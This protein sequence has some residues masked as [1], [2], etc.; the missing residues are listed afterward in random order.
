MALDRELNIEANTEIPPTDLGV[1]LE[2]L[3]KEFNYPEDAFVPEWEIGRQLRNG[4][5]SLG[6]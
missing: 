1:P 3:D 6:P 2:S 4:G 5:S